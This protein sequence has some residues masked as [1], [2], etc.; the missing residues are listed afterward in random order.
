MTEAFFFDVLLQWPDNV[1]VAVWMLLWRKITFLWG[2]HSVPFRQFPSGDAELWSSSLHAMLPFDLSIQE[3]WLLCASKTAVNTFPADCE[4]LNFFLVWMWCVFCST[5]AAFI[6]G[7]KWWT[8]GVPWL[9]RLVTSLSLWRPGF[10]PGSIQWDLWWTK[11][12]WDRFLSESYGFPLS[13]LFRGF[14]K[15]KKKPTTLTHSFIHPF[16]RSF[17]SRDER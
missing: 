8:Q 14:K 12:H 16:T 11:W 7:V 15:K 2:N 4:V 9:R 6:V 10:A 5:D 17:S 3:D 1:E 13:I